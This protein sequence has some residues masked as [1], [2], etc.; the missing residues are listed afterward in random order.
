MS[1]TFALR[2]LFKWKQINSEANINR[3]FKDLVRF[4]IQEIHLWKSLVIII[5]LVDLNFVTSAGDKN[6]F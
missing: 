3:L 2:C 4:E 6:T 1:T 5:S